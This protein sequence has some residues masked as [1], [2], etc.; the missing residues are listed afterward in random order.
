MLIDAHT[1]FVAIEVGELQ[2]ASYGCDEHQRMLT[3]AQ[4]CGMPTVFVRWNPDAWTM[5]GN[6]QLVPIEARLDVLAEAVQR[7]LSCPPTCGYFVD[8]VYYYYDDKSLGTVENI[9][10]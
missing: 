5:S 7:A 9:K 3:I 6:E 8:A 4:D 2:H 1:H 10:V